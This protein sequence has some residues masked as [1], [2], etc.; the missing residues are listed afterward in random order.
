[1]STVRPQPHSPMS[2][3]E[4]ERLPGPCWR[5]DPEQSS[6][7]EVEVAWEGHDQG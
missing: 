6:I 3:E 2:R 7:E 4:Q 1:M 5:N